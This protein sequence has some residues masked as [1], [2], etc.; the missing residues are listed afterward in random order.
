MKVITINPQDRDDY[1]VDWLEESTGYLLY[2]YAG[3][4][5]YIDCFRVY[6]NQDDMEQALETLVAYLCKDDDL[7]ETYLRTTQE[8]EDEGIDPEESEYWLYIDATM[9][10][11]DQPYYINI[12]DMRIVDLTSPEAKKELNNLQENKNQNNKMLKEGARFYQKISGSL[13]LGD[14][15]SF[16]GE[17][18]DDTG[19]VHIKNKDNKPI[20][21]ELNDL[22]VESYYN[23]DK[24]SGYIDVKISNFVIEYES[25][26]M[27]DGFDYNTKNRLFSNKIG[28]HRINDILNSISTNFEVTLTNSFVTEGN[29]KFT[30][31]QDNF[32]SEFIDGVFSF[33]V[34]IESKEV[35]KV[36]YELCDHTN[37]F[38]VALEN[39]DGEL[40]RYDESIDGISSLDFDDYDYTDYEQAKEIAD[41]VGG[42]VLSWVYSY[43]VNGTKLYVFNS[44]YEIVYNSS[45]GEF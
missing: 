6:C 21:G 3:G 37:Y 33:D 20:K 16:V 39:K 11:A 22:I 35:A 9:E 12:L 43:R 41:E 8:L 30:L 28:R 45:K 2:P 1:Y 42:L 18:D 26:E 40:V 34:E 5:S 38:S 4:Y 27:N 23:G 10:G 19:L 29:T 36:M 13:E 17:L 14:I 24:I 32:S 25:N 15:N 44:D 31:T 7:R